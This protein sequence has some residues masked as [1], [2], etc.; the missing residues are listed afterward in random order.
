MKLTAPTKKLYTNLGI[1]LLAG[2]GAVTGGGV[3]SAFF[4]GKG[5]LPLGLFLTGLSVGPSAIVAGSVLLGLGLT[6]KIK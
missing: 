5:E 6:A 4:L 3:A 2:G 1:G